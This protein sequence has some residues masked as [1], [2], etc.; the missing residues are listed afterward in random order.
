ML[1]S[2]GGREGIWLGG[3]DLGSPAMEVWSHLSDWHC[4]MSGTAG[5]PAHLAELRACPEG[6]EGLPATRPT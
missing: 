1:V 5:S 2:K 3:G 6:S 4:T